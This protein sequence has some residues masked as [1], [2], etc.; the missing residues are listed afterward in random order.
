MIF[1]V[2]IRIE[3]TAY[4]KS[5]LLFM[6]NMRCVWHWHW[7]IKHKSHQLNFLDN[8][9]TQLS[10]YFLET[11]IRRK[12]WENNKKWK[13][14]WEKLFTKYREGSLR[15]P[16]NLKV[17]RVFYSICLQ[18]ISKWKLIRR[19]S[20]LMSRQNGE[21]LNNLSVFLVIQKSKKVRLKTFSYEI[22]IQN[23]K[24]FKMLDNFMFVWLKNYGALTFVL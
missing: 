17:T 7:S 12:W 2:S 22:W 18:K 9:C 19:I 6:A 5:I 23:F 3:Q 20:I 4:P 8:S 15:N 21:K 24:Q 10:I 16:R 14:L 1:Y 13:L 11:S